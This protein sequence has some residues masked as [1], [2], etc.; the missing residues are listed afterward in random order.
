MPETPL[1]DALD[2]IGTNG[3]GLT[4]GGDLKSKSAMVEATKTA[5]NWTF[6]AA[7]QYTKQMGNSLLGKITWKPRP[8]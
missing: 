1:Q 2:R 8:K 3:D 6:S 7:W 5:G 4:A